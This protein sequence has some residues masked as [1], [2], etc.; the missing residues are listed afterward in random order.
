MDWTQRSY[1][2]RDNTVGVTLQ[3]APACDCH[4]GS[5]HSEVHQGHT[6]CWRESVGALWP[7]FHVYSGSWAHLKKQNHPRVSLSPLCTAVL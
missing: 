7:C 4:H 2:T 6:G 1:K 3:S 5:C